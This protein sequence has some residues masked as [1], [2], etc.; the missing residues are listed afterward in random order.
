MVS[1]AFTGFEE[2]FKKRITLEFYA[3]SLFFDFSMCVPL[4][5]SL[6]FFRQA[7]LL[8]QT[9]NGLPWVFITSYLDFIHRFPSVFLAS[10]GFALIAVGFSSTSMDP[11]MDFQNNFMHFRKFSLILL[12]F[13]MDFH[14]FSLFPWFHEFYT[15]PRSFFFSW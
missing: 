7:W 2:F 13:N 10:H 3:L 15:Q 14:C 1:Y 12:H 8:L 5:I 4:L 6:D 11:H 9:F